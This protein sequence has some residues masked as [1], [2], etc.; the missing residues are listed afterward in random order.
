MHVWNFTLPDYLSFL[1]EMN[2]YGLPGPERDFYRLAHLHRTVLNVVPYH[3]SGNVEPGWAPRWNAGRFDW[4][5]WDR[6]FGPYFDGSAFADLPR[7]GVPQACFYL[8][9]N[10]N[11][12]T[13]MEGNYNGDYWADRAFPKSY[14]DNF[15][16]ASRQM[17]EHFNGRGWNDTLFQCFFNGK[18]NFKAAGWSRGSSPWLLDEPAHFQDF[19]ALRYFGEAFHE[20]VDHAPG[21]A[22][23]LF[24]CDIS[25]PNGSATRWTAC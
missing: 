7:R 16:E 22:K 14:R 2:A 13:P 1:P 21:K 6:R 15:V 23:L 5:A 20:G 9:L 8:P 17:A 11:W 24:R 12:P 10:E 25:R 18:N 4:S 3:Q 19:W